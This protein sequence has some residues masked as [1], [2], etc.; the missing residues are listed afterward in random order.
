MERLIEWLKEAGA[1]S[2]NLE[3]TPETELIERGVLDSLEIL[4][5]VAFLEE[6]FAIPVPI[7]EFVPHNFR[8]RRR[9]RPL[10]FVWGA[11][12]RR[13]HSRNK[14]RGGERGDSGG[15]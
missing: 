4:R 12:P 3:I 13:R 14:I 7:E 9:S 5:L 1:K 8:R 15:D 11:L 6:Q 2:G 10:W